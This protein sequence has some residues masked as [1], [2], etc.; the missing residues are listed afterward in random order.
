MTKLSRKFLEDLGKLE[1]EEID[2]IL[3]AHSESVGGIKNELETVQTDLKAVKTENDNLK[4]SL[5]ER[6]TQL[7]DLKKSEDNPETLKAKIK[8]LQTK[9]ATKDEEHANEIKKIKIDFALDKALLEAKAKNNTA[10]KALLNLENLEL[11][12]DG[13]IKGLSE[14]IKSLTESED[15]K[16][17]FNTESVQKEMKGATPGESNVIGTNTQV[18]KSKMSYSEL[19]KLPEYQE[20]NRIGDY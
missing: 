1:K 8:E 17:L 10:V 5:K 15:T 2:S 14:Q 12:E 16:F 3:D 18:D 7:E 4:T 6:D 9:N 19:C 20:N 11:Q 13:S